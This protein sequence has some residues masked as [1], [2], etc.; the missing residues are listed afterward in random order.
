MLR[1]VTR[2][3]YKVWLCKVDAE[4]I[5]LDNVDA[6]R[7]ILDNVDAERIILDN[8]D[9]ERIILDKL[10]LNGS[11]WTTLYKQTMLFTINIRTILLA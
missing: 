8:V 6:E 10:M 5:I 11:F 7:I 9:A 4:K 2:E 1:V 3:A